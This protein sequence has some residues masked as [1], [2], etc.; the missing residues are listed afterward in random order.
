[1]EMEF[2]VLWI[3]GRVVNDSLVIVDFANRYRTTHNEIIDAVRDLTHFTKNIRP[4]PA[5]GYLKCALAQSL[6]PMNVSVA[7]A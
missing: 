6:I 7:S 4:P 3:F 2:A 1:M 5:A